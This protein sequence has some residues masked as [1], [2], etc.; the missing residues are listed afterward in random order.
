MII[1]NSN[2]TSKNEEN[3]SLVTFFHTITTSILIL[4]DAT[5]KHRTG[6]TMNGNAHGELVKFHRGEWAFRR[7]ISMLVDLL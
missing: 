1:L 3:G 4:L 5:V 7:V 6:Y 2:S